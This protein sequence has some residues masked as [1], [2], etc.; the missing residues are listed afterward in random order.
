MTDPSRAKLAMDAAFAYA[1]ER[2][3]DPAVGFSIRGH[4]EAIVAALDAVPEW[5]KP[6]EWSA[7][8]QTRPI[9]VFYPDGG[10][11]TR[12][13]VEP[14]PPDAVAWRE[15]ADP[16]AWWWKGL[17]APDPIPAPEPRWTAEMQNILH[18]IALEW[19][20]GPRRGMTRR[21][22]KNVVEAAFPPSAETWPPA[23][24]VVRERCEKSIGGCL[25]PQSN[26]PTQGSGGRGDV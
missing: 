6:E 24:C 23:G 13:I 10:V 11:R 2:I 12:W 17:E 5:R 22:R 4:V 9:E 19:I 15:S 1:S 7:E 3:N 25:Y 8:K 21:D 26:C 14:L 20:D 18:A 16:P